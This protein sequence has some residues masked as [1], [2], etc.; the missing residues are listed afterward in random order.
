[1]RK[2]AFIASGH[3]GSTM[4]LI[5]TFIEKG[6]AIDYF[7]LCN[8][9]VHNIEATDCR[10]TPTH[11]GVEEIP[12]KYWPKLFFNYIKSDRFRIF[13]ISTC[14]PFENILFL[15]R[16][17]GI[18]RSC[19]IKR[20]CDYI[21]SQNYCFVNFIGRYQVSDIVQ[22]GKFIKTKYVVSLHEVCN[23]FS[24]DFNR[25]NHVLRY[26]YRNRI[27]I[28]LFSDKSMDDIKKYK[29]SKDAVIYREN[30]GEFDSFK[31]FQ[32]RKSLA[33]PDDYVLF[34][35]RLTPY[36]GLRLFFEATKELAL[37]GQK[38]VVAGNGW[39]EAL[40]NIKNT[41]NYTII[42]RYLTDEDFVELVE[43]C[44]FVVCP[45]T[46]MSQSGIPQTVFVFNKTIVATDLDGFREII[47][48]EKN[49]ILCT[50][51]DK[52]KLSDSISLLINQPRIREELE[53]GVKQFD[54]LFP[55]YSWN[56]IASKYERDFVGDQ[57]LDG[58]KTS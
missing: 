25:S 36:K 53:R 26:L 39:D 57:I 34:I 8:K 46:S 29:D 13:S 24:P 42:N 14:R 10:Y 40:N 33:L 9:E 18:V 5:K 43:R 2:I 30:F 31:I 58:E 19:H 3:A 20:A 51:N 37:D 50:P 55:L 23:H 6:Y 52:K 47:I 38:F 48:D 11:R 44:S 15:N 32:G 35:G 1:M 4:P 12:S 54:K 56:E 22:Y 27:P 21:N 41:P 45:Y 49:G 17:V 16:V 7:I 28:I